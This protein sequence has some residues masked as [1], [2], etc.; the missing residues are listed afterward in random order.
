MDPALAD[1]GLGFQQV[2]LAHI[3]QDTRCLGF[4]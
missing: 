3:L 1:S 2:V 4:R